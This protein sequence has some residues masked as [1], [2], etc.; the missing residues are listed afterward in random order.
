MFRE[1]V[2]AIPQVRQLKLHSGRISGIAGRS[3][4]KNRASFL[5]RILLD[6]FFSQPTLSACPTVVQNLLRMERLPGGQALLDVGFCHF[7]HRTVERGIQ[8]LHI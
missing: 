4:D 3:L 7:D 8:L 6:V 1:L 5:G 2:N